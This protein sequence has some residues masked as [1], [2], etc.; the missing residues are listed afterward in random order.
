MVRAFR[1]RL[2]G[3][4]ALALSAP[5]LASS[6]SDTVRTRIAAYRELG[7]A[8]KGANDS[9]RGEVQ[10][11]VLQ[12]YARQIRNASRA[13][14]GW[15]PAG[16]GAQAGV[17][18]SAKAEIWSRPAE[19]KAAQDAFASQADAFQRAAAS[20]N[21][22]TLRAEARKLGGTCKG[23]HDSFKVPASD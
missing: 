22:A 21:A 17:R 20:G 4:L 1:P 19:F 5:L 10:T 2:I 13:Q 12:Q 15:F 16:T 23:C 14:Y 3:G 11:V 9:L 6:P 18:T 8:F 7:A